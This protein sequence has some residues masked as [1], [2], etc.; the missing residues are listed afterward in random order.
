M[1][2]G[3]VKL[4]RKSL[5]STVWQDDVVWKVWCWCLFK[6][7]T[8]E[9]KLLINGKEI[10]LEDG[11]FLTGREKGSF[12]CFLTVAKW[13]RGIATLK[14]TNRITIKSTK[15]YTIIKV[16]NWNV[17]NQPTNKP[18]NQT[19]NNQPTTNQQ[20]TT[21]NNYKNYKNYNNNNINLY[22]ANME[23]Q[24]DSGRY[25][26]ARYATPEDNI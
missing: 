19:T 23:K 4:H 2:D 14:S 24:E 8:I 16:I 25:Y 6:A 15:D 10:L 5:E 13:R 7:T 17:Y 18:T 3:W 20:P 21:N 12:D 11:E 1:S 26:G 22:K 9:R